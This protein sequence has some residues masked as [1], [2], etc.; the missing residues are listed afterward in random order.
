MYIYLARC[1]SIGLSQLRLKDIIKNKCY[2]LQWVI[3]PLVMHSGRFQVVG[4][5]SV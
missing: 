4:P 5:Q 1:N 3:H 2:W